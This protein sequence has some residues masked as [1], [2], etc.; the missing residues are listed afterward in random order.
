MKA[1]FLGLGSIGQRHLRNLKS[2]SPNIE[3]FAV[4]KKRSAPLL[5]SINNVIDGRDPSSEYNITEFASIDKALKIK[6]DVV[7]ITNP[8]IFHGEDTIKSI[9]AGA[10]VF[11]EKPLC[12]SINELNE[13]E[14]IYSKRK[15]KNQKLLVGFNRR[16]APKIIK[17]KNLL[18]ATSKPKSFIMT[19]NAGEL[20]NDHWHFDPQVGG[21]RI[22]AEVCHFIDL[23][24][25]L[26]G[27]KITSWSRST[28]VS[29]CNDSVSISLDFEDGS[30]G[31]IHYFSNGSKTYQKERLEIFSEGKI[32]QL[33][34]FRS[35]IGFGWP[36]FKK[37]K[38]WKIDKGQKECV[39][40]FVNSIENNLSCP[41]P[42]EEIFEV[43]RITIHIAEALKTKF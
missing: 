43:T 36:G 32:L 34:N 41:I 39:R 31:T 42:A 18:E 6:P 33:N 30:I 37:M 26:V 35:L 16:F 13:I 9:N 17:I 20:P 25:F 11:V 23:L 4:R 8:T 38:S 19:V 3:L 1:L 2:I 22:K 14:E 29:D 24:R 10:Y 27:F 40:Q 15:N 28:L 21:G 7:F 12:L 5:D